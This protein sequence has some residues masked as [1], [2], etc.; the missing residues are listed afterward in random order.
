MGLVYTMAS[1]PT[2]TTTVTLVPTTCVV[3]VPGVPSL[4]H[5]FTDGI[6]YRGAG[7]QQIQDEGEKSQQIEQP[8]D[9]MLSCQVSA[10]ARLQAAARGLLARR[11]VRE[12]RDLQLIQPDTPSHLLQV[13]LCRVD[14]FNPVRCATDLLHSVPPMVAGKLFSPRAANSTSASVAVWK[15]LP[16]LSILSLAGAL[17]LESLFF[18]AGR[19]EGASVGRCCGQFLMVVHVLPFCPDGAHGIQVAAHV[20]IHHVEGARRIFRSHK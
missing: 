18:I 7:V 11:R 1:T 19:H 3:V 12:M 17:C 20:H 14:E 9:K 15:A 5:P 13:A 4:Q 16:S 10:V 6:I 2:V 8:T